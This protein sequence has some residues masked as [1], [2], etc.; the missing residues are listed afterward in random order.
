MKST[1]NK[2]FSAELFRFVLVG[3]ISAVVEYALYFLFKPAFGYLVGNVVAFACT[4]IVT[5]ILTRKYVFNSS[6]ENK[7][8]EAML[9]TVCLAGALVTNQI[10]LWALVEFG[11]MDDR[12]AKIIAIAVTVVWN[13]FTR[14]HVVFRNRGIVTERAANR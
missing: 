4:N 1:L 11:Q 14:K 7:A 5:F 8:Q 10:A 2:V 9:F 3:G 12:I 6:D 13:F